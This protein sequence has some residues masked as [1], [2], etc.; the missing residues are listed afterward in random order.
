MAKNKLYECSN[1]GYQ[2][3]TWL[4]KC[5]D[6]GQWS[7]MVE[8]PDSISGAKQKSSSSYT[9]KP[10]LLA[11]IEINDT[12]RISIGLPY[13]DKLLGGG[14]VPGSVILLGGE[15]GIG[16]STLALQLAK[17]NAQTLYVC[18][19]ESKSQI[20]ERAKRLDCVDSKSIYLFED[21]DVMAI[22]NAMTDRKY[23]LIIVDS[24][25]TIYH[26]DFPNT[27]G[28]PVQ[29]REAS[30][31]LVKTA[32]R[33]HVPIILIGQVTKEGSVAGPRLLEH[34]VD[35]MLYLEGERTFGLRMIRSVKNRFGSTSSEIVNL[36]EKGFTLEDRTSW[37]SDE[38]NSPGSAVTVTYIGKR[39]MVVEIQ[40]L[41][42]PTSGNYPKRNS[43]NFPI[44]RLDQI[45]AI[46]N[47][48]TTTKIYGCDVFLNIGGGFSV[49]DPG[50][51]L[52]IAGALI[53]AKVGKSVPSNLCLLG[54]LSLTGQI[55]DPM[56]FKERLSEA[57]K[58][59]F[60]K[61]LKMKYIGEVAKKIF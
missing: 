29:L 45:L 56:F 54:E 1:C 42:E 58:I 8:V 21:T 24:V 19:E 23:N 5:F 34:M 2:S 40:A 14:L 41:V 52:A 15:P 36:S 13:M 12:K 59:G 50:I 61:A 46:I 53:S 27:P 10:Q 60:T 18:G 55:R 11:D 32:R 47:S 57:G 4:G 38:I 39:P 35:V 28:S 9:T 37:L 17:S 49:S 26:P 51:D 43:P 20:K 22:I 33:L 31:A 30:L 25:Q 3:G 44:A 7:T 6:C 16:K 48:H